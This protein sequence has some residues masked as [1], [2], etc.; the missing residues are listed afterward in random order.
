[1]R[2]EGSVPDGTDI[3]PPVFTIEDGLA[4]VEQSISTRPSA[5]IASDANCAPAGTFKVPFCTFRPIVSATAHLSARYSDPVF[6]STPEPD[7]FA[8]KSIG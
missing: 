2:V 3:V 8:T 7:S 5:A 1:M 6:V 4:S